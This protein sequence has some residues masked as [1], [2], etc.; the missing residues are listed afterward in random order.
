MQ[1][2]LPSCV[3]EATVE[4][5]SDR[6]FGA[7]P[8]SAAYQRIWSFRD[9]K[10]D[11]P[12]VSDVRQTLAE[13]SVYRIRLTLASGR[14]GTLICKND[15]RPPGMS[16]FQQWWF[17]GNYRADAEAPT[18]A[19]IYQHA[20]GALAS[21]IPVAYACEEVEAGRHYQYWLEDLVDWPQV[22]RTS[23]VLS[24]T[25][26][27][28][29]LHHALREWSS[30]V[31]SDGLSRCD[32]MYARHTRDIEGY[33]A[34]T[35]DPRIATFR[36]L[37][38]LLLRLA[39]TPD[40]QGLG[41][42]TPIHGDLWVDNILADPSDPERTRI[43]DWESVVLGRPHFD[44]ALLLMRERPEVEEQ[45]LSIYASQDDSMSLAEHWRLYRWCKLEYCLVK[46]INCTRAYIS[47]ETPG[48]TLSYHAAQAIRGALFHSQ[49]LDG[50]VL[51]DTISPP[52]QG[53]S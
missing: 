33:A 46:A 44:L 37:W 52:Q 31:G 53:K 34:Q 47:G 49:L 30:V 9:T 23:S 45:A 3:S 36:D 4:A 14:H 41:S 18:E 48:L 35:G 22:R 17:F 43:I 21:L 51:G 15:P 39:E 27:L 50:V 6:L 29:R 38:R 10:L 13:R 26:R 2:G 16:E 11:S 12:V 7:R 25:A 24:V 8:A 42:L 19:L 1:N 5:M 20:D 40:Y 28:P 32:A